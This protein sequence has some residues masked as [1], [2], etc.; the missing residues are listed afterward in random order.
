MSPHVLRRAS[1]LAPL[2]LAMVAG[3][4]DNATT[5]P[6]KSPMPHL[7]QGDGG[8]WTVNSLADPG[9]GV[10][11]DTE[12][13]LR[14]AIVAAAPG[15]RVAFASGLTGDVKLAGL[16][17]VIG[18][19][20]TIDGEGRIGVDAQRG[21]S[22]L[23]VAP[24]DVASPVVTLRRLTL[25]NGYRDGV[26]GGGIGIEDA[27]VTLDSVAVLN[28]EATSNG[29]GIFVAL[30]GLT[31][32]NSTIAGNA[33]GANGGGIYLESG[34]V[35]L[36]ASTLSTNAAIGAGG[37]I[38]NDQGAVTVMRSTISSNQASFGGALYNLSVVSLLSTTVTRNTSSG[39]GGY[40]N[41][42]T[43]SLQNSIVAGN[44]GATPN[45]G[46][47]FPAT[48][49]GRNITGVDCPVP[50][51][52]VVAPSDVFTT[53]IDGNL[54]DNGG[55]TKTHAA[56]ARGRAVDS[57]SC[58]TET[59]DQRGARRPFDDPGVTNWADGC[60]IGAYEVQG[61]DLMVSQSVDKTS[62]KQGD[63]LTYT[64]RVQS[65]GP[66]TAPNVVLNDVLS[67]G[68]TFVEARA[69]KG[70]ITA[71]RKGETGTVTWNLGTMLANAS[72]AAA[73]KVTVLV[74]GKTTI[75]STASVAGDVADPNAANNSAAITV[76]VAAG[77]GGKK[78]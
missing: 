29:G 26:G 41:N 73:I 65:L 43:M 68:V 5:A 38:Y 74:K 57:G 24:L 39:I 75:T 72:E 18:K 61:A 28:N 51:G 17:L 77:S 52:I 1:L 27:T 50:G 70:T 20:L 64:V 55:A 30:A 7:A 53:V 58:P 37:G 48:A 69:N 33:A 42:S 66:E 60:D 63:V 14:E 76:S 62:V 47:R 71:P 6:L 16:R 23:L 4:Q 40:V 59:A 34:T 10:C 15:G 25:K 35:T 78:P 21:S 9:D 8:L 22:V 12:C 56:I 44:E 11:D 45:C 46:G 13:T 49:N 2:A 19:S 32:R 3:C 36:T 54:K 31:V 67:S